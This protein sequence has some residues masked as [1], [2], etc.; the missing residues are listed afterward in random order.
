MFWVCQY[1][2][3]TSLCELEGKSFK[4]IEQSKIS[5]IEIRDDEEGRKLTVEIP[6]GWKPILVQR[7]S[8]QMT[9]NVTGADTVTWIVGART[10]G[11]QFISCLSPDGTVRTMNRFHDTGLFSPPQL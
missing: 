7:H 5:S 4:D 2:D 11:Q 8:I 10:E 3:G 1:N 9:D 6:V